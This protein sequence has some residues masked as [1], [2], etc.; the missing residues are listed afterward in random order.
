MIALSASVDPI[1]LRVCDA[2]RKCG[3]SMMSSSSS[4]KS[5]RLS[6]S[7]R[8]FRRSNADTGTVMDR[9]SKNIFK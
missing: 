3:G 6:E 9:K 7:L 5:R 2:Q 4:V 8:S 1:K